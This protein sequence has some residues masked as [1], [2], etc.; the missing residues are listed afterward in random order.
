MSPSTKSITEDITYRGPQGLLTE[1]TLVGAYRLKD[2]MK[3]WVALPLDL[4]VLTKANT[5]S[6]TFAM[7][8]SEDLH[9]FRNQI[10]NLGDQIVAIRVD[11]G[12]HGERHVTTFILG[13][14]EDLRKSIIAI[15]ADTILRFE[16]RDYDFHI[17]VTPR[18]D[19]GDLWL[20]K[21]SYHLFTWQV[22]S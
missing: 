5:G 20:P 1:E 8:S 6:E 13:E 10:S 7:E 17:R 4:P 21:G 14:S 11:Q 3:K 2:K 12:E 22:R 16:D 18:K 19:G 15:E 9:Y